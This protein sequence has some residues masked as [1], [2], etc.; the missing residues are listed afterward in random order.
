MAHLKTKNGDHGPGQAFLTHPVTNRS[1]EPYQQHVPVASDPARPTVNWRLIIWAVLGTV[2]LI[3]GWSYFQLFSGAGLDSD[4]IVVAEQ[5]VPRFVIPL[6]PTP[7]PTPAATSTP[8]PDSGITFLRATET[9]T[10]VPKGQVIALRAQPQASGW[11]ADEGDSLAA[12]PN[13]LGDSF[14]YAGRLNDQAHYG[15]LQFRLDDIPRG[16]HIAAASLRLTGLRD[17]QLAPDGSGE[18]YVAVID[19]EYDYRWRDLDFEQLE[20]AETWGAL[21][22]VL[23]Q[24]DIGVGRINQFDFGPEQL[25]L[26][27]RR[28]LEGSDKFGKRISFLIVG[29][30]D[31]SDNLFAW[32]SGHGS[33]TEGKAPELFLN[34]GPAPLETPPP[35]YVVVTSTPTPENV[36]TAMANSVQMTVEATRQGTATPLPPYWVTPLILTATPTAENAATAQVM[37]VLATAAAMTTGEPVNKQVVTPTPTATFYVV[38]DTP[39]PENVAT[40]WAASIQIT[41]AAAQFGT[42]TPLP[43]SWVTPLIVTSTPT[44]ENE[45]TVAHYERVNFT[46]GTPTPLPANAQTATP[47][48]EFN[49]IAPVVVL[50]T[51]TPTPTPGPI[52]YNFVGKVLFYSDRE[53]NDPEEDEPQIYVYDPA[54]GSLGRLTATWPYEVALDREIWSAD[55]RFRAFT[56]DMTRHL[57]PT[58]AELVPAVH[59]YDYLYQAEGRLTDF[60]A[61]I[62]Y[63]G[64]WS[65]TSDEIAFVSNDS[66]DDEIWYGSRDGTILVQLT[67]S[68]VEFNE[69]EIGKDTFVPEINKHPSWSPDGSQIVFFS[70]R[71]GNRQL[72][73]MNKDGSEQRLLMDWAPYNDWDPVW[74][75]YTDPAPPLEVAPGLK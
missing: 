35:H 4:P 14:L 44:P 28:L 8:D 39:T 43:E 46:T 45:A 71:T 58:Y 56:K 21:E 70:T 25:A 10:P 49:L 72:W 36:V 63:G 60:G 24:A 62:A 74:V 68:N 31:R 29:P 16:S 9:P 32:D 41:A 3:L 51:F 11:L 54:T 50:P 22:P 17:E 53:V 37:Q 33:A 57:S 15:L 18:W 30:Q 12:Q 64:V 20:Q 61:G 2:G 48:P 40:A 23:G 65:P 1:G 34:I 47:T 69:R 27:E 19:T 7:T 73:V 66:G 75:K 67:E 26:L 13:H 5:Q 42:A 59:W 55:F 6:S 52:P 38:D